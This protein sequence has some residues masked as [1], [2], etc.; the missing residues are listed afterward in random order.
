[1]A[2]EQ[3]VAAPPAPETFL[4]RRA[5]VTFKG[6]MRTLKQVSH[7]IGYRYERGENI[8][9]M[10]TK[11]LVRMIEPTVVRR[12]YEDCAVVIAHCPT[13][14]WLLVDF[15]KVELSVAMAHEYARGIGLLKPLVIET[16]RFGAHQGDFITTAIRLGATQISTRSNI[17]A[18]EASARA[19]IKAAREGG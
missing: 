11:E 18:D 2:P 12:F 13:K 5:R 10:W 3:S 1:M 8:L 7:V 17:F 9:K 6:R 19:A 16:F 4:T 15:S 14:P